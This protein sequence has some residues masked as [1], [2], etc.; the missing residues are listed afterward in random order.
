MFF[1]IALLAAPDPAAVLKTLQ[2]TVELHDVAISRDGAR[3][4][5]VEQVPTPDGPAPDRS[6]IQVVDRNAP[7]AKPLRVTASADGQARDEHDIAFSPDG[8][9]L[10]FLSDAASPRQLQLFAA[11]LATGAVRQLTRITGH[12]AHPRF[13]PDGRAI[14]VLFIEGHADAEGPLKPASR[15]TGVIDDQVE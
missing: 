10:A 15:R 12:L 1:A 13:R 3:V 4:G 9:T 8:G 11:D 5:W 14:A 7:A 6:V 2:S